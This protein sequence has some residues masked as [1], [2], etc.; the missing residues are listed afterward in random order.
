MKSLL[1]L[2][3]VELLRKYVGRVEGQMSTEGEGRALMSIVT[4]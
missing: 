3:L 4:R 1:D 2:Q